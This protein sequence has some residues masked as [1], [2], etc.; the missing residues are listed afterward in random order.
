MLLLHVHSATAATQMYFVH[1]DHLG[2][3]VKLTDSGQGVVW[4]ADKK[5]FGETSISGSVGEDSRFPGQYYDAESGTSYNYYRDYDPTLGR[6]IQSDPIG[7]QGG[8]NTYGYVNGNP[9]LY[10]DPSGLCSFF[11]CRAVPAVAGG[12]YRAAPPAYRSLRKWQKYRE[13]ARLAEAVRNESKDKPLEDVDDN[14]ADSD[15]GGQC[16][17]EDTKQREIGDP[18]TSTQDAEEQF[19]GIEKE[20]NRRRKKGDNTSINDI[21]KSKQRANNALKPHN[22]DY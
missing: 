12:I 18:W 1:N 22:I 20:Q 19:Q 5:P 8:L 3:P 6:Y 16:P 17:I 14:E 4:E 11:V 13:L 21:S 15:D 10:S 7:L 9:L 2:T